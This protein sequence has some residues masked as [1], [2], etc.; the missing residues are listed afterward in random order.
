VDLKKKY[1]DK[2]RQEKPEILAGRDWYEIQAFRALNQEEI[3]PD[4]EPAAGS[5]KVEENIKKEVMSS[6]EKEITLTESAWSPKAKETLAKRM[7]KLKKLTDTAEPLKENKKIVNLNKEN[8][9]DSKTYLNSG[10]NLN[11]LPNPESSSGIFNSAI[12]KTGTK[13]KHS[14]SGEA[15]FDLVDF[16]DDFSLETDFD[17]DKMEVPSPIVD[18]L[19]ELSS[20]NSNNAPMKNS[21]DS[22]LKYSTLEGESS[23]DRQLREIMVKR[24]KLKEEKAAEIRVTQIPDTPEK[25][26]DLNASSSVSGSSSTKKKS[27][28]MPLFVQVDTDLYD[29]EKK[30]TQEVIDAFDSDEDF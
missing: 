12:T 29:E 3:L 10:K 4:L 30:S 14:S 5:V 13:R 18:G 28:R 25:V 1:N 9:L 6:G 26:D 20:K 2:R 23:E 19:E 27:T 8:L 17:F 15:N 11:K 22:V 7:A 21:T 16:D 24:R